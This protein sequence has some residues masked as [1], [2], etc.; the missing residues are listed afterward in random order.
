MDKS[1]ENSIFIK[2]IIALSDM[3]REQFANKILK[4][5]C[6]TLMQRFSEKYATFNE[7]E[8]DRAM[9]YAKKSDIWDQFGFKYKTNKLPVLW[10]KT[11]DFSL[12]PYEEVALKLNMDKQKVHRYKTGN[13]KQYNA[14]DVTNLLNFASEIR[15]NIALAYLPD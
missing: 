11:I 13:T 6:P 3:N 10:S 14:Q 8:M 5:A 15:L 4:I 2:K 9:N 7:I 12:L 1:L